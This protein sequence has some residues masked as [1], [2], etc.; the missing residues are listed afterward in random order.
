MSGTRP[1]TNRLRRSVRPSQAAERSPSAGDEPGQ[2]PRT[3]EHQTPVRSRLS[4]DSPQNESF[5]ADLHQDI[6]WDTTSPSPHR[7]GKRGRRVGPVT[8]SDIV[9]RIA[10]ESGR[11]RILEPTLQ[12]W[13][14]DSAT[15]PCTPELQ[16]PKA[17]KKSPRPKGVDDLLRLAKQFDFNMLHETHEYQD[18]DS[19]PTQNPAQNTVHPPDPIQNPAP[20]WASDEDLDLLFDGSTQDVSGVFSQDFLIPNVTQN[21][22]SSL[23]N[24][25]QS[26]ST[27]SPSD[28]KHVLRKSQQSSSNLEKE[29]FSPRHEPNPTKKL[30]QNFTKMSNHCTPKSEKQ[31]SNKIFKFKSLTNSKSDEISPQNVRLV[32]NCDFDDWGD[33]DLMEDSLLM[34]MTQNPFGFSSPKS[35]STQR[36]YGKT[37]GPRQ[38]FALN[39]NFSKTSEKTLSDCNVGKTESTGKF[40]WKNSNVIYLKSNNSTM[41]QNVTSKTLQENSDLNISSKWTDAKQP[42]GFSTSQNDCSSKHSQNLSKN[43]AQV[44]Q[45]NMKSFNTSESTSTAKRSDSETS[46]SSENMWRWTGP[47]AERSPRQGPTDFSKTSHGFHSNS[48]IKSNSNSVLKN[49]QDMRETERTPSNPGGGFVDDDLDS[50]FSSDP[51]WDSP[52]DDDLLCELCEVV[53]SQIQNAA[54]QE[55][56]GGADSRSDGEVWTGE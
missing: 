3:H 26:K 22:H 50:I 27:V 35:T 38:T 45:N 32:Q 16:A 51:I 4:A 40:Q 6:V 55:P 34:E 21:C 52:K 47:T 20:D 28:T 17:K 56:E 48:T 37:D 24:D 43:S 10:P 29:P 30:S 2:T 5:N 31:H 53:E 18:P 44:C 39:H 1:R 8:I 41:Q 13:I 14:G 23:L 12:Q 11:P 25:F 15:I 19:D 46:H 9:N 36:N 42:A 54:N 7:L 33:D 49:G